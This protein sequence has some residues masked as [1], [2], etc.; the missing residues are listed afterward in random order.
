MKW[1]FKHRYLNYTEVGLPDWG[2]WELQLMQPSPTHHAT[3][4]STYMAKGYMNIMFDIVDTAFL[5]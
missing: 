3:S 5:Y 4:Q 2:R 1:I